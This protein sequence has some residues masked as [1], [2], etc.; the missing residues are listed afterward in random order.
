MG[1]PKNQE[2]S[3]RAAGLLK[4]KGHDI[5]F[6]PEEAD[7]IAVNTCGFIDDA[8]RESIDRILELVKYKE[9]DISKKVIVTGCLT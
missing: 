7:I 4:H 1:C 3:E 8:K 6:S 5:V 9:E 2:D